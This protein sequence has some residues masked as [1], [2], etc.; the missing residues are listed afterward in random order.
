M[1]LLT[2]TVIVYRIGGL[3]EGIGL[4]DLSRCG[5]CFTNYA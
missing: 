4:L 3:E 5:L 2:P 1:G